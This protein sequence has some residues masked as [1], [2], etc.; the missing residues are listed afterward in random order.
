V[1]NSKKGFLPLL[2]LVSSI[3]C[4]PF[5]KF[6]GFLEVS[7][8][9][10]DL[11][12]DLPID[13]KNENSGVFWSWSNSGSLKPF[14]SVDNGMFRGR[15]KVGGS[16]KKFEFWICSGFFLSIDLIFGFSFYAYGTQMFMFF[17]L[18][19]FIFF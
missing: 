16:C 15:L 7:V 6:K 19:F 18:W 9:M 17:F 8:W 3:V 1:K 14:R 11:F 10:K 4:F 12:I 2:S 13:F 5:E